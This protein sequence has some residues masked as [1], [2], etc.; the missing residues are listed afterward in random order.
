MQGIYLD[1]QMSGYH[2]YG[3]IVE[4]CELGFML[5]GGRD[6]IVLNNTY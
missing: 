4:N 2:V 1:D 6:N 3:N 5:G